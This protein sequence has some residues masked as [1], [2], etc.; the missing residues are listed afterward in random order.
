[1][2]AWDDLRATVSNAPIERIDD[3]RLVRALSH[4]LRV[5]VLAI[6]DERTASAVEISRML[7]AEL[8][9]V[10]YH[11]RKLH[12]LGLLTLEKEVPVR[13]ALQ[14]FYRARPRPMATAQSWSQAPPVAKQAL[15]GAALQQINDYAQASSAAGGFDRPDAHVTR[16]ALKLDDEGFSRLAAALDHVLREVDEIEA[17]AARRHAEEA[18][19]ELR[20]TG[21]VMLL[22]DGL[23]MGRKTPPEQ[24][25]TNERPSSSG[26]AEQ[27]A[28]G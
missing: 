24:A 14:R 21:L 18:T 12:E 16:T 19:V 8:G 9:V 20:E 5:R 6:L 17:D 13:G 15:I 3:P 4:P 7:R 22:F 11:M 1:L 28:G 10:A 2:R 26:G 27:P 23:S 25:E